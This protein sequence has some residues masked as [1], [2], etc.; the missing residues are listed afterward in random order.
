MKWDQNEED[1][2]KE[3]R[4][5]EKRKRCK[6]KEKGV[7]EKKSRYDIIWKKLI[8]TKGK[9][10]AK[11]CFFFLWKENISGLEIR[12]EQNKKI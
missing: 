7:K 1:E 5:K 2:L 9:K 4:K 6:G 11:V 3:E 8:S 12:L 10:I